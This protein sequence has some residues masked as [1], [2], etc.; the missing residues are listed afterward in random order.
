MWCACPH[1]RATTKLAQSLGL[2]LVT[3]DEH[4]FLDLTVDGAD[5]IDPQLSPHQGWWRCA[6]AGKN[7]GLVFPQFVVTIADESKLVKKLGTFPLPVE[8][9]PWGVKATAWKIERA[10]KTIGMDR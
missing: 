6:A 4:P 1:R 9:V 8:V 10:Y 2:K 7:R 3:L 5:E